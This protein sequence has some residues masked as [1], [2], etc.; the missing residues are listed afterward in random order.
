[1]P[2]GG[3]Y[4]GS[5]L[6]QRGPGKLDEKLMP[7]DGGCWVCYKGGCEHF[8]DEWD[9]Y[10]HARCVPEFLQTEEGQCVIQHGHIVI[11]NFALEVPSDNP[12]H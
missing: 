3:I 5:P 4:P 9:T 8:C 7:S 12:S 10:I 1:M 6:N 2:C 11:L